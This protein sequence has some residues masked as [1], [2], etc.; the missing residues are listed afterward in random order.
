MSI[1]ILT[2]G[3]INNAPTYTRTCPECGCKFTYKYADTQDSGW[4][5]GFRTVLCPTCGYL[6]AHLVAGG[7]SDI[8]HPML[9]DPT[10]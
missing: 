4:L 2:E 3:N 1:T 9:T 6:V 10:E 5:G 8:N 7:S